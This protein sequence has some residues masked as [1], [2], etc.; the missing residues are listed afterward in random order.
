MIATFGADA[1]RLY[2]MFVAPPEKEVEWTDSG[3]E[4]SWRFLCRVWRLAESLIPG[5]AGAA[6]PAGMLLDDN[7][8][9]LRRRTHTTIKRVTGEIDPRMHLNTAVSALMEHV[10]EIYA[11]CQKA[12]PGLRMEDEGSA[13]GWV[14]DR[15]ETAA[16]L[17]EAI[18]ALVLLLSPFTPH[19]AEEL[20]ERLG[21][22]DG[23]VAAGWPAFDPAAA[24]EESIEIPVQVNGKVRGRVTVPAGSIEDEIR[25]AAFSAVAPHL[26]GMDVV[27]VVVPNGRL[28][29]IVVRPKA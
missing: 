29:S 8:R 18:E 9:A 4:G 17:R 5:I 19:L 22:E 14:E 3:L 15:A 27:K 2:V 26:A 20:W 12:R 21:H 6:S 1:L 11:F 10:N 24:A 28:V 25:A 23:I 13:P 7:E 16:V